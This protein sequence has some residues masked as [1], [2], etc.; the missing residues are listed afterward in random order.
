MRPEEFVE[1]RPTKIGGGPVR[2][3]R[4]PALIAVAA[5]ALAVVV[6]ACADASRGASKAAV[7]TPAPSPSR[8]Q[9][10]RAYVNSIATD[11]GGQV[12]I[13][14]RTSHGAP[15][16]AF[17]TGQGWQRLATP[18]ARPHVFLNPV[19]PAGPRDVWLMSGGDLIHWDG[20]AWKTAP[21]PAKLTGVDLSSFAVAAPND[22]WA[23]GTHISG[24]YQDGG[25][26]AAY[27]PLSL[28]WDGRSWQVVRVPHLPGRTSGLNAVSALGG[29]VWAVGSYTVKVGVQQIQGSYPGTSVITRDEPLALR[30]QDG[31]WVR[32]PS[33]DLGNGTKPMSGN[34]NVLV[35]VDVLGPGDVWVLGQTTVGARNNSFFALVERWDGSAWQQV[36]GLGSPSRPLG[37]GK[38]LTAQSDSDV[39]VLGQAAEGPP[40]VIRWG[41]TAWTTYPAYQPSVSPSPSPLRPTLPLD[42]SWGNGSGAGSPGIVIDAQGDVWASNAWT[43]LPG[44]PQLWRWDGTTWTLVNVPF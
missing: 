31:H 15:F 40:A 39:W 8:G 13:S 4:H 1:V 10:G 44:G 29:E 3:R 35:A 41:G 2:R 23:V 36:A 18:P 33:P 27:Q 37:Y 9:G 30:W 38:A 17:W 21:L 22:I 28:H 26:T 12:W 16:V 11:P 7:V 25:R 43:S 34:G 20:S 14:G 5:V 6:T 19:A 24:Y 42:S 32:V